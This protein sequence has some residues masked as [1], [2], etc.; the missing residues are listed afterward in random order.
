MCSLYFVKGKRKQANK[1][2]TKKWAKISFKTKVK[3]IFLIKPKLS[4]AFR[5]KIIF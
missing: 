2:V 4:E 3:I 1:T 5:E